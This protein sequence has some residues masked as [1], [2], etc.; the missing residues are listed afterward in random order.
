MIV[1]HLSR[2][3]ISELLKSDGVQS[4]LNERAERVA[5]TARGIVSGRGEVETLVS[6]TPNRARAEIFSP[7]WVESKDRAL[8]IALDSARD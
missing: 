1:F 7:L 5:Q 6:P 2:V 3:G 8:G 4:D